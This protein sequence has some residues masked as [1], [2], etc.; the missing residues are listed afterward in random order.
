M[1]TIN[2]MRV[3][4]GYQTV[5][6]GDREISKGGFRMGDKPLEMF[7]VSP[8]PYP[9]YHSALIG[10]TDADAEQYVHEDAARFLAEIKTTIDA[11]PSPERTW[12][13]QVYSW[14]YAIIKGK[15]KL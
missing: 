3:G 13:L 6:G 10:A 7:D 1:T 4:F 15:V 12:Q 14:L 8:S 5:P 2:Q 9:A 11:P